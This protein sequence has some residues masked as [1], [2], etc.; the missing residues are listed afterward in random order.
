MFLTK[1][2]RNGFSILITVI[3]LIVIILLNI[4]TGMLTDRFFLKIDLTETGLFTIS[5]R[6]AEFLNEITETVDI[7]ILAEE[8]A[9]IANPRFN[10]V[11]NVL[12][13][14][15]AT[16]GGRLRIQ[17]VDPDLNYFNGPAYDNSLTVLKEAHN[18][19]EDMGRNDI[20]FIS[21]RRATRLSANSL[22]MANVDQFGRQ[23]ELN[24]RADQELVSALMYVL[25]EQIARITFIEGHRES[26][27]E[28]IKL[29]FE[30]SGYV[31][32]T[33]N[34]ALDEIP[35][36]TLLLVSISPRNDFL[37]EEIVKMEEFFSL[38]G[39]IMI[40]YDFNTPQLPV[41][42]RFLAEWGVR[43]ENN[44]V[45]DE[46]FTYIAQ[47][48]VIGAGVVPLE[49][50]P[51]TAQVAA[52]TR[53]I[54]LGA[55]LP[56]SIS[57]IGVPTE[58][59][60]PLVQTFSASSFAKDLDAGD[61][62]SRERDADDE[63]GPFALGYNIRFLTRNRENTQVFS[64][65]M[66]FSVNLFDDLFLRELGDSFANTIFI[67]GLA[68]DFNPFGQRTFIPA[69]GVGSSLMLVSAGG[70]RMSLFL[71][72]IA[73]PLLII[74]TGIFVWRKRRHK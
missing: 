10:I 3:F 61:I 35:E 5:D 52:L 74:A 16:S 64:N 62:T 65:L 18:E 36:D 46:Q 19:L 14:F 2:K 58:S 15:S 44:L 43:V 70:T 33:V 67:A 71:M 32:S 53:E 66:V 37:Q 73:L 45:F 21:S 69:K 11:G 72:V 50:L 6:A 9:W 57:T 42:D 34:L 49:A 38:G 12:Q 27:S 28:F 56:R 26:P 8:M 30:R 13:N 20:I 17:Y 68:N 1:L 60:Q 55:M 23:T 24:F 47:L 51:S 25:N 4:F 22:F 48:G 41:L 40:I 63:S 29:I 39:N 31:S 59:M 54:P 7:V